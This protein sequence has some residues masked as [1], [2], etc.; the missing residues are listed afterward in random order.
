MRTFWTSIWAA[1]WARSS[2]AATVRRSCA[3]PS[4]PGASSRRSLKA[5][6]V[7]V[8]VK[9]PQGLGR[10]KRQRRGLCADVPAGGRGRHAVHG[11]TRVQMYAG[12]ADWDII[13]DVKRAVTIPVIANG[14]I[15]SGAD[16]AHILRYTGAD[17]AMVGRG[18][19]GDPWLFARG[20]AA[21]AGE[22]EPPLPPLRERIEA[23]LHQIEFAAEIRGERLACLEAR[24]QFCWYLRGVPHANVYKQEVVHVETL[25]DLRR[26]KR[27]IQRDL[28]D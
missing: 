14:D 7:P 22:P 5:V 4:S 16:A 12:R 28:R 25:D 23:A 10:R 19:F 20:N 18:S 2:A 13:R 15:F 8:T 21:I 27:A 17:L 26:I 1:R 9:I 6:D 11:R 3:I 24:S